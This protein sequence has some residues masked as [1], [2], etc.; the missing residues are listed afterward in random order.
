MANLNYN[1]HFS[2]NSKQKSLA[3]VRISEFE[4]AARTSKL[5]NIKNDDDAW[6]VT[7]IKKLTDSEMDHDR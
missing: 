3:V 5:K 4:R 7:M 6:L 1:N 2:R